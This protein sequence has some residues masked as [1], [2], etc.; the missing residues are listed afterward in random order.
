MSIWD[1]LTGKR[2]SQT[3]QENTGRVPRSPQAVWRAIKACGTQEALAAI[4]VPPVTQSTV[5]SWGRG[6]RPVPA[7]FC[8]QIERETRKQAKA[9]GDPSLIATCEELR[10]DI[11][12]AE[13][14]KESV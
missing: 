6:D 1:Q 7:R 8:P 12:W 5:S 13:L 4:L 14:R 9:K 11:G 2:Q 10:P 3:D